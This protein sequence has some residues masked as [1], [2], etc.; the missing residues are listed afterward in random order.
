MEKPLPP[1]PAL[2]V[3]CWTAGL[4]QQHLIRPGGLHSSSFPQRRQDLVLQGAWF[5]EVSLTQNQ[6]VRFNQTYDCI[7]DAIG[8]AVT[9]RGGAPGQ[10]SPGPTLLG[11]PGGGLATLSK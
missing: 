5:L 7:V 3:K 1:P 9:E 8:R 6:L 11:A 10:F 2:G 4:H